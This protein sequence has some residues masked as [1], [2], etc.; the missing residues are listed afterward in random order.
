MSPRAAFVSW[1]KQRLQA[2][3][4]PLVEEKAPFQNTQISGNNKNM[5]MDLKGA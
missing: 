5:V 1:K 4:P 2:V 3:T